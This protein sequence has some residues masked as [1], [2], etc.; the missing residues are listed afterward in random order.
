MSYRIDHISLLV[1]DLEESAKFY[2]EV[3]GLT[4]VPNPMGGTEIRWFE[5]GD[6]QRFQMQEGDVSKVH[7]EKATHFALSSS[8]LSDIISRLRRSGVTF[9]NFR[10]LPDEINVRPDGM[11]AIFLRDPTGYWI[12]LNDF[13]NEKGRT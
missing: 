11:R 4:E 1:R 8:N 9:T 12:E 2:T 10:G 13:Q 3:V 7:V 6:N 5:I